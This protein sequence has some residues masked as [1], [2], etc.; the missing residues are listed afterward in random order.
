MSL[1]VLSA[2]RLLNVV[3]S[4]TQAVLLIKT[5]HNGVG[6]GRRR[7][8]PVDEQP[9]KLW[10]TWEQA[11]LGVHKFPGGVAGPAGRVQPEWPAG[12]G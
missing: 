6:F 2:T 11:E 12:R 9:E 8:G 7:S 10:F 5:D 3:K 4:T 1:K